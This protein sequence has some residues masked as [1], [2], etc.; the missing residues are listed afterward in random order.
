MLLTD[1]AVVMVTEQALLS[2]ES[3]LELTS[4]LERGISE[5][6]GNLLQT[7]ADGCKGDHDVAA[8]ALGHDTNRRG[9]R[10]RG[11]EGTSRTGRTHGPRSRDSVSNGKE[12]R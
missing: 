10:A 9:T 1:A 7:S 3:L 8:T 6:R 2:R 4:L 11:S 5:N 12:N